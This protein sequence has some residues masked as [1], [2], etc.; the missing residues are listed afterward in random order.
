MNIEI[1]KASYDDLQLLHKIQIE[2]FRPLL[3]KYKDY[4]TNPGNETIDQIVSVNISSQNSSKLTPNGKCRACSLVLIK[5]FA[6]IK[7]ERKRVH[8]GP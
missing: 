6:E 2:A 4:N 5:V 8:F 1:V 7:G 3:D